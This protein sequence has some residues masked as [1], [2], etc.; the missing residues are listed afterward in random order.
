MPGTVIITDHQTGGRGQ[1]GRSWVSEPGSNLTFSIIYDTSFLPVGAQ[2]TLNM[3]VALGVSRAVQETLPESL[4]R[5]KWPNDILCGG[6]KVAGILIENSV[7]GNRLHHSIVGIG[8]NVNQSEFPGLPSATSILLES[9]VPADREAILAT[10]CRAVEEDFLRLRGG[11]AASIRSD[12][13]EHLFGRGKRM[14]WEMNGDYFEGMPL[15]VEADGQLRTEVEGN[16]R[17]FRFGELRWD[18]GVPLQD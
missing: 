6:K 15:E 4:V 8:L 3:A 12:Y 1:A 7:R 13:N 5:I 9:G 17:T 10:V 14:R 11:E 16:V 18:L 2:Y